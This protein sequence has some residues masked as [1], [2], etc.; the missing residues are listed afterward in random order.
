M[1]RSRELLSD[2]KDMLVLQASATDGAWYAINGIR[3]VHVTVRGTFSA[4]VK[5]FVDN[6]SAK[7]ANNDNTGAQWGDDIT[8][9]ISVVID[10]PANWIKVAVTA[11]TSGSITS[12]ILVG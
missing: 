9:P 6:A 2:Q 5:I 10:A 3:P 4:T 11:F 7:P 1:A 8:A 12:A